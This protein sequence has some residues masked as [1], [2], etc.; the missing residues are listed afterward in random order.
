MAHRLGLARRAR[1][2]HDQRRVGGGQ[3]RGG[4]RGVRVQPLVAGLEHRPVEAGRAHGV[5]AVA[6]RPSRARAPRRPSARAGRRAAAA[7]VQGRATAPI[8][9]HASRAVHPLGPVADQGH[10]HVA[11]ADPLGRKAPA[12]R[13]ARSASSP[14]RDLLPRA[15]GRYAPPARC[16]RVGRVDDVASRSSWPQPASTGS[17]EAD[18][19]D[20]NASRADRHATAT[21][22]VTLVTNRQEFWVASRTPATESASFAARRIR[23]D[24]RS[25]GPKVAQ[26][27]G[28]NLLNGGAQALS[29]RARQLTPQADERAVPIRLRHT[30]RL[31]RLCARALALLAPA[32]AVGAGA[33]RRRR[34]RA[35]A[36]P[37]Q[38]GQDRER[39]RHP[40]GRRPGPGQ[41]RHRGRQPDRPQALRL[42]RRPQALHAR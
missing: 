3:V 40:A 28:A 22:C 20:R 19:G 9:K 36:A 29:A 14:K 7:A 30:S 16:G 41:A 24:A 37:G 26:A 1:G 5:G 6:R 38:E 10:D 21:N 35:A 39:H 13:P 11:A 2:E 4:R 12:S 27:T 18:R 42:R 23:A 25:G 8:R 32:G 15:A 17:A 34:V 31:P 33:V